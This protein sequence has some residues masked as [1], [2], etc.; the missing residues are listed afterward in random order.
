MERKAEPH[1][2]A[3]GRGQQQTVSAKVVEPDPLTPDRLEQLGETRAIQGLARQEMVPLQSGVMP[4][5]ALAIDRTE[6]NLR[7]D[8]DLEF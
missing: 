7:T 6:R 2:S 1:R 4:R 8:R 5:C 3:F